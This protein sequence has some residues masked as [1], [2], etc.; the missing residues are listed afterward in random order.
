[1]AGSTAVCEAVREREVKRGRMRETQTGVVVA[2]LDACR[3]DRAGFRAQD[4]SIK[5][6]LSAQGHKKG[7]GARGTHHTN[8]PYSNWF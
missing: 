6:V 3:S 7:S 5:Q 8:R 2:P 1:V 4:R